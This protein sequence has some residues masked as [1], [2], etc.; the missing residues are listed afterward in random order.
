[1]KVKSRTHVEQLVSLCACTDAIEFA[2]QFDSLVEAWQA[3]E[4]GDWMLWLVG[5]M[6]NCEPWSEGRK[7]LLACALDCADTVKHLRGRYSDEIGRAVEVLRQWIR[8]EVS[9]EMAQQ[10]RRDLYKFWGMAAC[11]AYAY[12]AD[13]AGAAAYAAGAA[14][15]AAAFA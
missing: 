3:C 8:G 12:A 13:A 10:V 1:M 5:R 4:R 14:A 11:A 15:G 9:T 6:I 7:P 2:S